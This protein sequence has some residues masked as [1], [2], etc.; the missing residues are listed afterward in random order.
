MK[1]TL[2]ILLAS[3][4]WQAPANAQGAGVGEELFQHYC[5]ACHGE[6][7]RGK[8]PMAEILLKKP[9]NLRRLTALNGG[10]FPVTRVV[11]RI[12]GRDPLVGHGSMM[13]VYGDVF[14]GEDTP[15]KAETGQP[16]M[17]SRLIVDVVEYLQGLQE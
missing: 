2:L 15:I 11:F 16:I 8:G 6:D 7:A 5:A 12:D 9:A 4:A 14:D 3:L 13:P 10:V 1:R 17:T